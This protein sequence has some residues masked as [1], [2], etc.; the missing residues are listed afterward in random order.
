MNGRMERNNLDLEKSARMNNS[1]ERGDEGYDF[2][3]SYYSGTGSILAK[4]LK[5]HA[6][7]F[8]R[9]AFFDNEDIDRSIREETDEWRSQIDEAIEK[10]E[11]FVLIMTL[12]FQKRHEIRRE[13]KK[14]FDKGTNVLLF[15]KEGL[16]AQELIMRIDNETIDFSRKEYTSFTNECDLLTKVE[17]ALRGKRKPQK[18]SSFKNEADRLIA[19]EGLEIKPT[20]N[21]L[22]EVI[23]GARDTIEGWLVPSPENEYLVSL[24]P[25]SCE[26]TARR[27]FFECETKGRFFLK[28]STNGFFH[29]ILPLLCDDR[30]PDLYQVN[31]IAQQIF[32]ILTYCVRIMKFR[33]LESQQSMLIILR[34]MGGKEVAFTDFFSHRTHSFANELETKFSFGFNPKDDWK[35]IAKVLLDI[36]KE[37]CTEMGRMDIEESTIRKRVFRILCDMSE[38][39]REH[40]G[41][42]IVPRVNINDFGLS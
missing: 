35:K 5:E 6:K 3:I 14:A 21:P 32:E 16:D 39:L 22:L 28:V 40:R 24:F 30:R 38:V 42:V 13:L 41:L 12:G 19:T 20:N 29:V 18:P 25:Y 2:F 8:G 36:F 23:V 33:N 27:E 26:V 17:E 9:N 1:T 7:D 4:Y 37:L 15:K 34:N 11:N 31:L 10:S